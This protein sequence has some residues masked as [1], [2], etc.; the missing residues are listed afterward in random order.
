MYHDFVS[1]TLLTLQNDADKFYKPIYVNM[2]PCVDINVRLNNQ[3]VLQI[4][5]KIDRFETLDYVIK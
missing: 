4:V 1:N 3:N 2:A 5:Y